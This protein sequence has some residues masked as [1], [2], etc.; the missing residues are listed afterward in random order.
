MLDSS[1]VRV[2]LFIFP[3]NII[4]FCLMCIKVLLLNM[5]TFCMTFTFIVSIDMIGFKPK[6]LLAA[7]YLPHPFPIPFFP[8]FILN[9]FMI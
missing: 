6:I 5:Y 2:D 1:T 7:S 4:N 8:V 3:I 9:H